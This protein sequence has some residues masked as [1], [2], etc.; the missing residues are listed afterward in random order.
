MF[1]AVNWVERSWAEALSE[2]T[3]RR[4]M[5]SWGWASSQNLMSVSQAVR[6]P[7]S[8]RLQ[9]VWQRCQSPL[10]LCI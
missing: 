7:A 10:L 2:L 8:R 3:R 6:V 9:L 4:V 1:A 5:T